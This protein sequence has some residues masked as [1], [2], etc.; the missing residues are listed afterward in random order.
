LDK[1]SEWDSSSVAKA[2]KAGRYNGDA[3]TLSKDLQK[4]LRDGKIST[5][6]NLHKMAASL[7][8]QLDTEQFNKSREADNYKNA[9]KS[10]INDFRSSDSVLKEQRIIAKDKQRQLQYS[11]RLHQR[12]LMDHQRLLKSALLAAH[13]A[14]YGYRLSNN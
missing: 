8:D 13:A 1:L 10:V 7:K 5:G 9:R 12:I 6:S 11:P 14:K 3:K 2:L 4:A